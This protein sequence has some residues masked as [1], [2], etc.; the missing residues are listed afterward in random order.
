M[1]DGVA[2]RPIVRAGFEG[3]GSPRWLMRTMQRQGF[4]RAH[5]FALELLLLA[6]GRHA[7][8]TLQALA[9][10]RVDVVDADRQ[11]L[12]A[13]QADGLPLTEVAPYGRILGSLVAHRDYP[14]A[15]DGVGSLRGCR[16]G[17]LSTNDK[18]WRLLASA[19]RAQAG[20]D[21][22]RAVHV[23]HYPRRSELVSAL[24][25]GAVDAALLHWH[26][27]PQLIAAGHH[28]LAEL[29][30]LADALAKS[31]ANSLAVAPGT[32]PDY[33]ASPTTFF[34]MHQALA[35]RSPELVAGFVAATALAIQQ[36]RDDEPSWQA[37]ADEGA[38]DAD[39]LAALRVRW[40]SRIG[41]FHATPLNSSRLRS[42]PCNPF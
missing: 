5:G 14:D 39:H 28:V 12:A 34:V 10:G 24:A 31:V 42:T 18:N 16:L 37:L 2:V 21:L 3:S 30:D 15:N 29:P 33:P 9:D 19:C 7:H 11:A 8:G 35:E 41:A 1:N 36:L 6:E 22:A 23:V 4:D 27:V 32:Q 20:F 17:V 26:L 25:A 40:Q 38:V 13:A